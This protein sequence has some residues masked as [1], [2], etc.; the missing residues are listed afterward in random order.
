MA[1]IQDNQLENPS[2]VKTVKVSL[3]ASEIKNIG[4]TPIEAIATPGVGKFIR[5]V[6]EATLS[7]NWG[8]IAF[9]NNDINLDI[10]GSTTTGYRFW[11]GILNDTNDVLIKSKE[12]SS[13]PNDIVENAA[14]N[15]TGTDSVA[16]GDSIID[17]YITYEIIT[18]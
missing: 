14:I 11:S 13:I 7:L 3:T 9:D 18:L 17:V 10:V 6:G 4:T 1:K 8:S 12:S 16:T 2:T 5:I 15:I